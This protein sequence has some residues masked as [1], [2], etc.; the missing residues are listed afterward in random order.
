MEQ[1]MVIHVIDRHTSVLTLRDGGVHVTRPTI[2]GKVAAHTIRSE[3]TADQIADWLERR[4]ELIQNAFP[5]MSAEDREFLM[6]GIT[7]D[8][9][10]EM[11]GEA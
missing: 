7:P 4:P 11:F 6:T 2:M 10:K 9:W 5:N 3:Y 1:V 8:A